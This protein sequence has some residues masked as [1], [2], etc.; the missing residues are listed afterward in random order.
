LSNWDEF[1]NTV[2]TA[3]NYHIQ[4]GSSTSYDDADPWLSKRMDNT[5][6]RLQFAFDGVDDFMKTK[7]ND[8]IL[9]HSM[10]VTAWIWQESGGNTIQS[11]ML[12][13]GGDEEFEVGIN[14]SFLYL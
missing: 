13:N 14:D 2:Y 3:D 4:R 8:I 9:N 12:K 10:S 6:R 11:L 7:N 1:F 5:T